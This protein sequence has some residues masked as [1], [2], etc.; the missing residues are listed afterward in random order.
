M[1]LVVLHDGSDLAEW[2]APARALLS[3]A[4]LPSDVQWQVGETAG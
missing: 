3:E 4:V 1:R 2:R